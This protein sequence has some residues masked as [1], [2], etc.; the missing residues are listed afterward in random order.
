MIDSDIKIW[1]A[2]ESVEAR[3]REWFAGRITEKIRD[4]ARSIRISHPEKKGSYL[5]IK[6]AGFKGGSIAFGQL[7]NGGPRAPVFDFDGR[8]M[9]DVSSGH[10]NAYKGGAS[11]QQAVVEYR[12]S[13]IV[14]DLDYDVVPCLGY[15]RIR[16]DG[17]TSWFSLFEL[18]KRWE[19]VV[20]PAFS[21]EEYGD[22][23]IS[24]S[25]FL[26]DIAIKHR[27]IG[28]CWYLG[29]RGGVRF[30]KDL[31]PFRSTDPINMSQ[32]SWVMQLLF[33]LHTISL[34]ALHFPKAA[35]IENIPED[36]QAYIFRDFLPDATRDEHQSLR[37]A[38]VSPYMLQPPKSF[39]Q[40]A[41]IKIL[42]ENRITNALMDLCPKEYAHP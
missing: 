33:A 26:T 38:L 5:K 13:R 21:I 27:L 4:G 9:E 20:V 17:Y 11:F 2:S 15:G 7:W 41:L 28:H 24:M 31:H 23:L 37:W 18:D 40:R 35:G 10:D 19:S 1:H 8:M 6:G 36:F 12:M 39:D 22:A 42:L 16:M 29:E 32:L 34:S 30:L 25:H 14:A 3:V